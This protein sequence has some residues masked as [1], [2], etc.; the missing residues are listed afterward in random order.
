MKV[1][2]SVLIAAVITHA[3]TPADCEEG[4]GM[5]IANCANKVCDLHMNM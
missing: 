5:K 1:I 2:L 4:F 3:K